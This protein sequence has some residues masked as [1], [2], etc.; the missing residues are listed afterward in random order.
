MAVE[1]NKN[2]WGSKPAGSDWNKRTQR[3]RFPVG[4][5]LSSP[6]AP[7]LCRALTVRLRGSD[8]LRA[9]ITD[10]ISTLYV[11]SSVMN[12]FPTSWLSKNVHMSI[13]VCLYGML[14]PPQKRLNKEIEE[15]RMKQKLFTFLFFLR[16]RTLLCKLHSQSAQSYVVYAR[17]RVKHLQRMI[18]NAS[19]NLNWL[20]IHLQSGKKRRRGKQ[21]TDERLSCAHRNLT[22]RLESKA[23]RGAADALNSHTKTEGASLKA[24]FPV[25]IMDLWVLYLNNKTTKKTVNQH[26]PKKKLF[27]KLWLVSIV[28]TTSNFYK[29]SMLLWERLIMHKSSFMV[30]WMWL[31]NTYLHKHKLFGA[32]KQTRS[33]E[34][35]KLWPQLIKRHFNQENVSKY[36]LICAYFISTWT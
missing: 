3:K 5:L 23:N 6:S 22:Q 15:R 10:N 4:G 29:R 12:L 21:Q 2:K 28:P 27:L 17:C 36:L 31:R 26:Q 1:M 19:G 30:L 7:P 25:I 16:V 11:F 9:K 33:G 32:R 35:F 20:F 18:I 13:C 24:T 8:E 14:R 34:D